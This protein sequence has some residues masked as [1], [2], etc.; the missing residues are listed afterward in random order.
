MMMMHQKF[1]YFGWTFHPNAPSLRLHHRAV[2]QL[3]ISLQHFVQSTSL[4]DFFPSCYPFRKSLV[5]SAS[6]VGD[7]CVLCASCLSKC[8]FLWRGVSPVP[9]SGSTKDIKMHDCH[10]YAIFC[11]GEMNLFQTCFMSTCCRDTSQ[12]CR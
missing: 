12:R 8:Q 9:P 4:A 6:S 1:N 10:G 11:G 2:K 3:R 7:A 5:S